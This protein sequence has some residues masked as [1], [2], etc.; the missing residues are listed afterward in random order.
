MRLVICKICHKMLDEPA[1]KPERSP[2]PVCGSI[3]RVY[4]DSENLL[5]CLG[6]GDLLY[7]V[8]F[9][10]QDGGGLCEPCTKKITPA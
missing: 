9:S 2:C 4:E 1:D 3:S 10:F 5:R 7:P 6:C 8:P